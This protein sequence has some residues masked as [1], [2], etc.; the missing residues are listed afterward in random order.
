MALQALPIGGVGFAVGTS[1]AQFGDMR[2]K[3]PGYALRREIF[4]F[5]FKGLQDITPQVVTLTSAKPRIAESVFFRSAQHWNPN[6]LQAFTATAQRLPT[7]FSLYFSVL[8][9]CSLCLGGENMF[10]SL[11]ACF[12]V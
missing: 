12:S 8:P 2:R 10:Q 4:F 5:I 3:S 1:N 6:C 7:G 11:L 9:E